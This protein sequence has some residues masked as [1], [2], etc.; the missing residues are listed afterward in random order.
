MKIVLASKSP[1][2][3]EILEDASFF[4][5][6]DISG[7]DEDIVKAQVP[8]LLKLSKTLAEMKVQ[9]VSKR[10]K[11]SIIIGADTLVSFNGEEIG[12]QKTKED[13]KKTLIRLSGKEHEVITGVCVLN[14]ANGKKASGNV[15]S[16][17]RL[18][19]LDES[20]INEYV[21]SGLY[22]GKAGAYNIDD[23]EF[24]SYVESVK[25][26]FTN[27]K[28]LPIEKTMKMIKEVS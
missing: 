24:K 9:A 6:A 27:I 26:S 16:K 2:R 4:V 7:V 18:K 23:P 19:N 14:T 12:Q 28:G 5:E 21:N 13:A 20:E 1:R 22:M 25:G 8:D 11:N 3:K 10:H 17:T 15:I